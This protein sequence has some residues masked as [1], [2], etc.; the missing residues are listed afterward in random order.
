MRWGAQTH[1]QDMQ[2]MPTRFRCQTVQHMGSYSLRGRWRFLFKVH[3]N[4]TTPYPAIASGLLSDTTLACAR[5][6]LQHRHWAS[7]KWQLPWLPRLG[8][9][10]C[11]TSA[12]QNK[13][14]NNFFNKFIKYYLLFLTSCLQ[15]TQ[16]GSA[17]HFWVGIH[18][19]RTTHC[20]HIGYY[21][22]RFIS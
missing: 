19:L 3:K 21:G 18:Q 22:L 10:T 17:T 6:T 7:I 5:T 11:L 4:V 20:A 15:P 12:F 1:Q 9:C 13:L 8:G 16:N 14:F 2:L